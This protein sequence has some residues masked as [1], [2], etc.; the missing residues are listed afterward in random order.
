[1]KKTF[2]MSLALGLFGLVIM[3]L[4]IHTSAASGRAGRFDGVGAGQTQ[5]CGCN[6]RFNARTPILTAG[7][8]TAPGGGTRYGFEPNAVT[9]CTGSHCSISSI[10]YSWTVTGTA[11]YKIV[12]EITN[13]KKI[14]VDVTKAGDV[15][16]SC[17]VTVTCSDGSKCS[18]TGSKTFS[19]KP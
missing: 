17:T 3:P 16:L 1:M 4:N 10:T 9:S 14:E 11:A 6:C 12:G 2:S 15:T 5:K 19:L 8:T 7:K 13:A 18:A